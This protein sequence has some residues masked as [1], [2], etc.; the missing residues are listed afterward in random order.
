MEHLFHSISFEAYYHTPSMHRHF[1]KHIIFAINGVLKCRI[2]SDAFECRG[3]AIQSNA[4]HTL[5][6][7]HPPMLVYLIDETCSLAKA[8]DEVYLHNKPYAVLENGL[9]QKAMEEFHSGA[10]RSQDQI[11]KLCGLERAGTAEYDSRIRAVLDVI[12]GSETLGTRM[13]SRL[14]ATACLSE[15]RLSHLFREEVGTSMASYILF[16][17]LAKAY[18]YI[19]SG[20]NVTQAAI[21]SGFSSSSHFAAVNKRLFGISVKELGSVGDLLGTAEK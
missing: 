1:A 21:H 3:V 8:L 14:C 20:E 10:K 13:I 16:S 5:E 18:Q 11:L 17:K 15:S 4:L 12:D 2:N 7:E 9:C 19:R 6:S